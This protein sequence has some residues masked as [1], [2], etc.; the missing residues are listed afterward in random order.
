MFNLSGVQLNQGHYKRALHYKIKYK[1]IFTLDAPTSKRR[2]R[3]LEIH[4]NVRRTRLGD[5]TREE[6]DTRVILLSK[7]AHT[8]F[9][10]RELFAHWL[11]W[12]NAH[13]KFKWCDCRIS[14]REID[15]ETS[16]MN[17]P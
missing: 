13:A 12:T 15:D 2:R 11:A 8:E 10:L 6:T 1:A 17:A 5:C 14:R 4:E 3:Q 7:I 9:A 16:S